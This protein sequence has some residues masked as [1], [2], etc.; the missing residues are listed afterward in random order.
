MVEHLHRSQSSNNS[1]ETPPTLESC[2]KVDDRSNELQN[3]YQSMTQL[4]AT[5]P[6]YGADEFEIKCENLC[7]AFMGEICKHGPSADALVRFGD[8]LGSVIRDGEDQDS[9][10]SSPTG[11]QP[12]KSYSRRGS[13]QQS[14]ERMHSGEKQES[15]SSQSHSRREGF[16]RRSS[17]TIKDDRW[18]PESSSRPSRSR[19]QSRRAER[20]P[21]FDRSSSP[22]TSKQSR[23]RSQTRRAE[24]TT[25]FDR[26]RS[27]SRGKRHRRR[28]TQGSPKT[29]EIPNV[30]SSSGRRNSTGSSPYSDE[31]MA[32]MLATQVANASVHSTK[33][34]DKRPKPER[35]ESQV[36]S[37]SRCRS[38]FPSQ[39]WPPELQ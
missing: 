6:K 30:Q 4:V 37:R 9:P 32:R 33:S 22:E 8:L 31:L 11:I 17:E 21:S 34:I 20:T 38:P 3:L 14:D 18:S 35:S 12:K 10:T 13:R 19:S 25:S 16:S 5:T 36:R 15:S 1:I 28:G 23:S 27:L 2:G 7:R 39:S 26:T 29:P 24:R